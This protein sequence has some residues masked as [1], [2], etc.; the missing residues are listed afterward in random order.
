MAFS[1]RI[2]TEQKKSGGG[3][4]ERGF[5][6]TN[7]RRR[8]G[9][10]EEGCGIFLPLSDCGPKSQSKPDVFGPHFQTDPK[11]DAKSRGYRPFHKTLQYRDPVQL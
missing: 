9:G 8:G 7:L 5:Q 11:L 10:H 4:L 6:Y 2:R 3:E 1:T